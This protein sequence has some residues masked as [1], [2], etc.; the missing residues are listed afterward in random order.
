MSERKRGTYLSPPELYALNAA[1]LSLEPALG[2]DIYLVGS[3]MERRDFRDVD[4]RCML[5]DD[6]FARRFPSVPAGS[7]GHSDPWWAL[8]CASIS[9][10]L[11][12][13]TGLRIDF[14]I[15]PTSVANRDHAGKRS[16]LGMRVGAFA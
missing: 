16:A 2:G 7:E 12:M 1:C 8:V 11:S 3:V 6:D 9:R 13:Q 4:V 14:Q 10:S 5:D 15:Q